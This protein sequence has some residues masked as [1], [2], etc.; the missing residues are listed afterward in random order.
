MGL[1]KTVDLTLAYTAN[2][3]V[4]LDVGMW[5][6]VE[7]QIVGPTGTVS[8]NATNDSGA[9]T[10]VTDGNA[11]SA[12]NFT[13]VQGTN[14]ATGTAS[15]TTAAAGTFKFPVTARFLQLTGGGPLT[16]LL[17]MFYKITI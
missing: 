10:G 13:P 16:E 17:V 5:D 11:T 14:I 1:N 3:F 7:A 6:N 2:G 8:F 12:K 9:I 4:N 15:T